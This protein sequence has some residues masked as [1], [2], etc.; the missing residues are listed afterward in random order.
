MSDDANKDEL[1]GKAKEGVGKATGDQ[2]L[3]RQG[4]TDQAKSGVKKAADSVKD[5]FKR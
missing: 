2:D 1:K 4:H 3:E 5:A